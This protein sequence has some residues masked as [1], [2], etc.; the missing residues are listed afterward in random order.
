MQ[1][2]KALVIGMGILIVA[3]FGL[4]VATIVMRAGSMKDSA[5]LGDLHLDLPES[6]AIAG[7]AEAD[8]LLALRLDGP[9]RDGCGAVVLVDASTREIAGRI[10]AGTDSQPKDAQ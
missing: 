7:I 1:A 5:E 2:L 4:V 9:R 6:C 10:H 8:G 3:G